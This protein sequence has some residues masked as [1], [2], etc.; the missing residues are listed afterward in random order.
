MSIDGNKDISTSNKEGS[1]K[2][3]SSTSAGRGNLILLVKGRA[4]HRS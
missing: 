3:E 1:G 2:G 4:K